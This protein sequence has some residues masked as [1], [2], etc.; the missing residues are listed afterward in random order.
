MPPVPTSNNRYVELGRELG[1]QKETLKK[2]ED[3]TVAEI[4]CLLCDLNLGQYRTAFEKEQ[5][6][7]GMLKELDK[8]ILQTHFNMS[9]YHAHKLHKA[10]KA[11]WRPTMG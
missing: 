6:D 8:N 3:L 2:V 11:G 5:V 7:G 10:A 4:G 9:V 1:E